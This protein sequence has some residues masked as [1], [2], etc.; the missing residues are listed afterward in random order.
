MKKVLKVCLMLAL[1]ISMSANVFA[2][3][4]GFVSSP[5][6][7]IAP[8]VVKF[9]PENADCT[10]EL[11]VTPY[12]DRNTLSDD[13]LTLIEK[14]YS[15]ISATDDLTKLTSE[16]ASKASALGIS[17]DKLAVSDLF[18]VHV[19]GCRKHD[20]HVNFNIT[21]KA[22]TLKGFVALLHMSK[23]GTWEVVDNAKVT[24]DEYLEFTAESLTP[25]AVVVETGDT[26]S[27]VTTT[28]PGEDT[29]VPP[30]GDDSHA[31]IYFAILGA[32]AVA[33]AVLAVASKKRKA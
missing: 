1:V 27:D 9:E 2:A 3:A 18:D 16:L 29:P 32:S 23:D 12:I 8:T 19:E 24:D 15:E 5:S 13:L 21:L 25:F 11:I 22:D 26:A 4:G 28:A 7:N 31:G 10:A 30:T 17:A 14:A 6:G 20:D 33:L